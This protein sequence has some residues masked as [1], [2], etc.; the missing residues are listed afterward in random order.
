MPAR[1]HRP[2]DIAERV[3]EQTPAEENGRSE[4]RFRELVDVGRLDDLIAVNN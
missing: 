1:L 3:A 4:Y 2:G